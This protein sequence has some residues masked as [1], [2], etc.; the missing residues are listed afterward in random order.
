M[1][2]IDDAVVASRVALVVRS[3]PAPAA[4]VPAAGCGQRANGLAEG[5]CAR[6]GSIA[7]E[8]FDGGRGEDCVAVVVGR[9][10]DVA[11]LGED[12]LILLIS[13]ADLA[14]IQCAVRCLGGQRDGAVEQ[15]GD[16]S[17]GSVSGLQHADAGAGVLCRLGESGDVGMQAVREGKAC[18]IV[19]T[20]VD[21]RTRRELRQCVLQARLGLVKG[22]FCA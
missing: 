4:V 6:G 20:A 10:S 22:L 18:S 16:L 17:Q 14:G 19:G 2:R 12:V 1:V 5:A 13:G 15:V 3:A 9:R 11:D 21:A 7:D 8:D